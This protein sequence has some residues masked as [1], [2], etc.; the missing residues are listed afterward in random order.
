M[1]ISQ[2]IKK[3]ES[4]QKKHGNVDAMF[5]A[6]NDGTFSVERVEFRVAEEDEYPEDWNMPA[7]T[8]F[9]QITD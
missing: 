9:V 3:L 8:E 4:L 2:L 6:D 5:Y 7:G 1:K